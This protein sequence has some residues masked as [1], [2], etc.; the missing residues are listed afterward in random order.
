MALGFLR[1][2]EGRALEV[3]DA[4]ISAAQAELAREAGL[5]VEPSSA[6]AWAGFVKDRAN[7]DA[8]ARIVVLLTGTGFKDT[9]AAEKLVSMPAAC[10]P[11]LESASR[12]LAD[13]YGI[14]ASPRGDTQSST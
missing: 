4:E 14:R 9:A 2:T 6:A 3:S 7:L 8:G 5:F 10:A 1:R 13:V 12:L 11:D